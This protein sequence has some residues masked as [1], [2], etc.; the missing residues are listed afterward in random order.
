MHIGSSFFYEEEIEMPDNNVDYK[1]YGEISKLILKG[2]EEKAF[3][4]VNG[5]T[6][7][8]IENDSSIINKRLLNILFDK[9]NKEVFSQVNMNMASK[10]DVF[11]D[12]E[13]RFKKLS[14]V[15][16][17]INEYN[18]INDSDEKVVDIV[19]NIKKLENRS[20]YISKKIQLEN[21]IDRDFLDAS[22]RILG[23]YEYVSSQA[24]VGT[25]TFGV[26]P[27]FKDY[28]Y[29]V[30]SKGINYES[31]LKLCEEWSNGNNVDPR[32]LDRYMDNYFISDK[33]PFES[34]K[35]SE[36]NQIADKSGFLKMVDLLKDFVFPDEKNKLSK[37]SKKTNFDEEIDKSMGFI[38]REG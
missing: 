11:K 12:D 13:E 30:A 32:E 14:K 27:Y 9:N 35:D 7:Y 18:K 20:E 28:I 33:N 8:I 29:K 2:Y 25:D 5:M 26:L 21:K 10:L 15:I 38:E 4:D 37:D 36:Q 16:S 34:M 1:R 24:G 22:W 19:K 6:K 17:S 3:N 23:E 31:V